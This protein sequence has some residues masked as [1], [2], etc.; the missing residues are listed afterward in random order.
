MAKDVE[1]FF[2]DLLAIWT[3]SL[4]KCLSIYLLIG[5]E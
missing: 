1:Y 2:M 3:S 5:I 4:E